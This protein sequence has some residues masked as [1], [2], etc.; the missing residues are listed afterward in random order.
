M[1]YELS[2]MNHELQ[3]I[4]SGLFGLFAPLPEREQS[5]V[6]GI[7]FYIKPPFASLLTV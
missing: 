6:A 7:K 4:C 5:H 2:A 1:N 3:T